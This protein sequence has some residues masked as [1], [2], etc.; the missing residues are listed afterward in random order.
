MTGAGGWEGALEKARAFVDQL[1]LEEKADM[2]TGQ[3]GPCVG[4]IGKSN[5]SIRTWL[6]L[7]ILQLLSLAWVSRVC[8]CRTDPWLFVLQ[9]TPV[10]SLL[11]CLLVVSPDQNEESSHPLT[12]SKRLGTKRCCTSE[13]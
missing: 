12:L 4:N 10:Y 5:P 2:V 1:T 3:A 7:N 6:M 11:V 9:T 8:V 13:V